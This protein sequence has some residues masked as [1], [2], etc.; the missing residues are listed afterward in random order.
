MLQTHFIEMPALLSQHSHDAK[1][2]TGKIILP[3]DQGRWNTVEMKSSSPVLSNLFQQV[4]IS[5]P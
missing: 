3:L 2:T 1:Y 5:T 4:I